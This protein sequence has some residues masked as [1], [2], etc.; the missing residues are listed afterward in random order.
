LMSGPV[1]GV[2]AAAELLR[3]DGSLTNLVTLDIGG[4]SADVA[5][6]DQGEP[7]SRTLGQIGEWPLM[8]PMVDIQSIG[9]G[10]GS[11]ARVDPYGALLV[12][13]ESA[14][15]LP[16][17]ACYGHG[18][19]SA[20][21]TDANLLLGRLD[22]TYFAGGALALDVA[23]AR[24]AIGANVA[25][26]YAMTAE[27]ASLGIITVINSTMARLLAEVMIGHGYDPR[28]FSLLAFGGAGPL[29]ACA[30]AQALGIR[31]VVVPI[32]PGTF[33]AY[34][35]I[36]AD[37]RHDLERMMVAAQSAT[38]EELRL[39]F[40]ELEDAALTQIEREH[41]GYESVEFRRFAELRYAGQHHP[42]SVEVPSA[43]GQPLEIRAAIE[44]AFHEKHDR[45]YGFRRADTSVELMRIQLSAIGRGSRRNDRGDGPARRSQSAPRRVRQLYVDGT[46]C[47]VRVYRRS[48]LDSHSTVTG[49]TIVEEAT[50]TTYLP[51]D[52]ALTVDTQ[53]NLRI[54]VP[55]PEERGT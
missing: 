45:L 2:A 55:R 17:P 22:P 9:A 50:S 52:F 18:G 35:M 8:V 39:A 34:G 24:S 19:T 12:G 40:G 3:Q 26:H 53:G 43:D 21:V 25:D 30:L 16:G 31:E 36:A 1:G 33:S 48:E 29:H 54:A 38:D 5:I 27:K 10:G 51:P 13:P 20:T 49:P 14:G 11:I 4:T 7:V 47:E 28:D 6:L 44:G 23:A 46:F 32:E 37:V 15:A 41:A 42:L